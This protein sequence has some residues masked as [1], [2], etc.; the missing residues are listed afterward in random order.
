[1]ARTG[2][3]DKFPQD[4]EQWFDRNRYV[5]RSELAAVKQLIPEEGQ[6]VEIGVGT[7]RFAEP[8]GIG[9]GVEP[10]EAM[11]E[12][13]EGKGLEVLEGTAERLPLEDES[14]DF[15]LMVTTV[16]FLDDIERAFSEVYRI[17]KPGG[18]FITGFV[19]R[20]SRVGRLYQKKKNKSRFYAEATFYST[21]EVLSCLMETG[22][23]DFRFAQTIFR[24]LKKIDSI[25]PVK[26]GFEEGSFVVIRGSK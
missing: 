21:G 9:F 18:L 10:S 1:M 11:R 14:F 4:Y 19:D 25:E 7:G 3:F 8:L 22:F 12:I 13:A 17:L 15:A 20:D 26:E 5:Y 6:G 2:P 24:D 23:R 16:C